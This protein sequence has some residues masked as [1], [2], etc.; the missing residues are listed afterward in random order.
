MLL[1][2]TELIFSL[3][4]VNTVI[5]VIVSRATDCAKRTYSHTSSRSKI[6]SNGERDGKR[7]RV[8]A[9]L[10]EKVV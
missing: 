6:D 3:E 10:Q 5:S 4:Y 7:L 2:M 8:I 1:N 9:T